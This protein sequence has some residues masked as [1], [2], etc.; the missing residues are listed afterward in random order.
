VRHCYCCDGEYVPRRHKALCDPC[1]QS[2]ERMS[3]LTPE[4]LRELE[5]RASLSLARAQLA[6]SYPSLSSDTQPIR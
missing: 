1:A 4:Q 3:R 2:I 5:R 6:W